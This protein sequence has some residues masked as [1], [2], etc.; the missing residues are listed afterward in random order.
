MMDDSDQVIA[1]MSLRLEG[2]IPGLRCLGIGYE[3]VVY[4]DGA[5][6]Y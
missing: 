6:V 3:S 2:L 5:T 1:E 4:T